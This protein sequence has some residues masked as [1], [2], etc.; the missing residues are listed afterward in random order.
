MDIDLS[1]PIFTPTSPRTW[2]PLLTI[3]QASQVLNLSP[4]TLR[5]WDK[6]GKLVPLRIGSRKDRRYK[7]ETILKILEEGLK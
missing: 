5:Q 2:P 6:L 3:E 4:W 1:R 7:K